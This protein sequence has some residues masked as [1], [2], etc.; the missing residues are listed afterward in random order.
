MKDKI[1]CKYCD[2]VTIHN[3]YKRQKRETYHLARCKECKKT[4][5]L[6]ENEEAARKRQIPKMELGL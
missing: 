3:C 6:D 5:R 1:Y 2:K 4:S